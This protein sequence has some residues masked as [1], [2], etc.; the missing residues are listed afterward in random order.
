MF[1][2]TQMDVIASFLETTEVNIHYDFGRDIS[3]GARFTPAEQGEAAVRMDDAQVR[4][5]ALVGN[6]VQFKLKRKAAENN[7]ELLVKPRIRYWAKR[8][9][10]AKLKGIELGLWEYDRQL[11]MKA[12]A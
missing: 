9:P 11:P 7:V 8:A 10:V 12:K 6:S 5:P 4:S 3:D 2:G 1:D